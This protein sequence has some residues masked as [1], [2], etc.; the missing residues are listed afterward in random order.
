MSP[1]PMSR[2]PWFAT[3]LGALGV[4]G[5]GFNGRLGSCGVVVPDAFSCRSMPEW[6]AFLEAVTR[7]RAQNFREDPLLALHAQDRFWREGMFE[8]VYSCLSL[9]CHKA[10]D[11][12][13]IRTYVRVHA[14][15]HACTQTYIY[16]YTR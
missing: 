4:L 11:F 10:T 9:R 1:R 3:F 13:Y 15:M 2:V 8:N 12:A 5:D 7:N 6:A 14:C 16:I